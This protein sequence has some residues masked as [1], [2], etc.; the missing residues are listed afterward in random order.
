MCTSALVAPLAST[1]TGIEAT[2]RIIGH[3]RGRLCII[4]GIPLL[5]LVGLAGVAVGWLGWL[6]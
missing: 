4:G 2:E 5:G 3:V 6:G 1:T